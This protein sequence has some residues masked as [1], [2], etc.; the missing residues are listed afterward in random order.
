[1]TRVAYVLAAVM[2]ITHGSGCDDGPPEDDLD[3]STIEDSCGSEGDL[4]CVGRSIEQCLLQASGCLVWQDSDECG[5]HQRCEGE[6]ADLGCVCEE[7]CDDLGQRICDD[8][9]I[10]ECLRDAEGCLF[11]EGQTNCGGVGQVCS[12]SEGTVSCVGCPDDRCDTLGHVRCRRQVIQRC[13]QQDDGCLDWSDLED[14]GEQD[15]PHFCSE[16]DGVAECV[17][18][19]V[20]N[21]DTA[22]VTRCTG[23][24]LETCTFQAYGCLDWD[25][26]EDCSEVA[27][28]CD[29]SGERA[30]CVT[31][32]EGCT[33]IDEARC[34]D[35][36][37]T[38]CVADEHGCLS[39]EAGVDCSTLDPTHICAE[40]VDDASCIELPATGACETPIVVA[41]TH[42]LYAGT[43][44]MVDFGN[45]HHFVGTDCESADPTSDAVFAV[46]LVAGQTLRVRET[47][48]LDAVLSLQRVC[49]DSEACEFSEDAYEDEGYDYSATADERVYVIVETFEPVPRSLD[50]EIRIDIVEVEICD[51]GSDEDADGRTDCDDD[52][53]FGVAPCDIAETNCADSGD[54]DGDGATDCDDS[55]CEDASICGPYLGIYELFAFTDTFDLAGSSVTF[56]PDSGSPSGYVTAV[57]DVTDYPLS[58]GSGVLSEVVVLADDDIWTQVF[59]L[60]P[61]IELWGESHTSMH[62]NSNGYVSFVD[63]SL[64]FWLDIDDFFSFPTVAG[65]MTDLSP[66]L[67][68]TIGDGIV[69]VDEF[70]DR[71]A[72]TF[73]DVPIWYDEFFGF[74]EGPNSFQM[75]IEDDG[76]IVLTWLEISAVDAIVGIANGI[77]SGDYPAPVDLI[78]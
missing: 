65:L 55:D 70:V 72:V 64:S 17:A 49:G 52:D 56:T 38:T 21:C 31:C 23:V 33:T 4:R 34:D 24:V 62:V 6:G 39:W 42:A 51:D 14:C 77:G 9:V 48:D 3:C 32:A 25:E 7:G 75:I 76:T 61:S 11:W 71:I 10:V 74:V 40:D 2:I 47:G 26:I 73:Q 78:P 5:D 66:D 68:S 44:F 18:E 46:D 54:N 60:L 29:D 22:G 8:E 59:T 63:W 1:M 45:D 28:W 13:E 19:C 67:P 36:V 69:T 50:Y 20:H 27:D 41:D 57:T 58:P 37:V 15:P 16:D 53:C 12:D 43:D 35:S 30:G